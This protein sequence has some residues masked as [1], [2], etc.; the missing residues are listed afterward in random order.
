MY[1]TN[2]KKNAVKIFSLSIITTLL[3]ACGGGGD[4]STSS[5]SNNGSNNQNTNKDLFTVKNKEWNVAGTAGDKCY[6]IDTQNEVNCI[7]SDWD[8]KVTINARGMPTLYTNGGASATLATSNGAA[9]YSPHNA[10]WDNVSK[11]LDATK[12]D[13]QTIPS[14]AWIKDYNATAFAGTNAISSNVFEYG[15]VTDDHSLWPNYKVIG[16]RN[17]A[18]TQA[19]YVLQ[20]INYYNNAKASGYVTI[21]YIDVKSNSAVKTITVNASTETQY[22]DLASGNYSTAKTGTWQIA[23]NRYNFELNTD[24]QSAELVQPSGFYSNGSVN[25]AKFQSSTN[26]V[27][28]LPDLQAAAQQSSGTWTTQTVTSLLNPKYTGAYPDALN[29]GF[30]SYYP[31]TQ[32]AN[33]AGL[34]TAHMLKA[35]ANAASIIR[36]N[37][38]ASY[39]RLH[40]VSINYADPNNATSQTTWKFVFDIQPKQ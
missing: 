11:L 7:S 9:L 40:L 22:V 23:V 35:N 5:N 31:T 30:F 36:G 19:D 34:A 3:V 12:L 10:T 6:D 4:D 25:V 26:D 32:V 27:D 28:T 8:L 39:A 1:N 29:Y 16:V 18:S 14:S 15:I 13:G 20:V 33:A 37:S 17:K 21:R 24:I 38:G 2:I